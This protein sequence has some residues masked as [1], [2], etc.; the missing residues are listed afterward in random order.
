MRNFFFSPRE[1]KTVASEVRIRLG[2]APAQIGHRVLSENSIFFARFSP[3]G[4]VG[5]EEIFPPCPEGD[6]LLRLGPYA[7]GWT[8]RPILEFILHFLGIPRECETTNVLA[9]WELV[10]AWPHR[11]G[12]APS[13]RIQISFSLLPPVSMKPLMCSR[14]GLS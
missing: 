8:V 11:L 14:S 10:A 6:K 3:R 7:R 2:P 5:T 4:E 13:L 1:W 9:Q 12:I